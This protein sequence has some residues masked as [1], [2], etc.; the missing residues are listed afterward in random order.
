MGDLRAVAGR[1]D[2]AAVAGDSIYPTSWK[3]DWLELWR[4]DW[5]FTSPDITV[6]RYDLVDHSSMSDHR[7]QDLTLSLRTTG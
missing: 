6:H 3:T 7:L 5:A 4:V 2:D 1:L